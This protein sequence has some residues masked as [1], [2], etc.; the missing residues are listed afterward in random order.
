TTTT[1]DTAKSQTLTARIAWGRASPTDRPAARTLVLASYELRTCK[2]VEGRR[3]PQGGPVRP[4]E[5]LRSYSLKPRSSISAAWSLAV[6]AYGV[7]SACRVAEIG[8]SQ[9]DAAP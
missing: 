9:S 1:S 2:T 3:I 7:R 6:T 4:C 8:G 5:G